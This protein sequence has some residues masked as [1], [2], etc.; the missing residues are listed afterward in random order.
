MKK[1]KDAASES[2]TVHVSIRREDFTQEAL[3]LGVWD[4][5]V[6]PLAITTRMVEVLLVRRGE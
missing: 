2:K 6:D 5:L 4:G 3:N 1:Q